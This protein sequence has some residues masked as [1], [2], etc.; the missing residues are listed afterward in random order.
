MTR[1][2]VEVKGQNEIY[3]HHEYNTLWECPQSI[4]NMTLPA[5]TA[6]QHVY[7]FWQIQALFQVQHFNPF[8]SIHR[9]IP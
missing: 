2:G 4:R 8:S 7:H 1:V 3:H 9:N 6:L 5:S